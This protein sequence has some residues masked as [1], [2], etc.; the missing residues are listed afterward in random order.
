MGHWLRSTH[1]PLYWSSSVGQKQSGTQFLVHGRWY[2]YSQ[3]RGQAVPQELKV[4][5]L[6]QVGCVGWIVA[7][8]A[9]AVVVVAITNMANINLC[10]VY[11]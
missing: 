6:G 9:V 3:V 11:P 7:T 1:A 10:T 5:P 8:P 4:I 2:G